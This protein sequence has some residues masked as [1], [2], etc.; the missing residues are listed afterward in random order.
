MSEK[1]KIV[2][3]GGGTAGW[4]SAAAL[5]SIATDTVCDVVLVE[6]DDIATVGVGEATIP[7]IQAFNDR[8]G[9]IELDM[10][11]KTGATFKLGI[12][13]I[14]WREKG[15]SYIHPFGAFGEPVAGTDF[16]QQWLR[17]WQAGKAGPLESYSFAVQAARQ[18][19]FDFP[20]TDPSAIDASFTY[21]YHLDAGL[22]AQYLRKFAEEKGVK[23]I[24][25]KVVSVECD[26][27][28]G[29][30]T[31][32]YLESG[33]TISGDYFLDCSGFRSLLMGEALGVEFEPWDRWLM[34]DRAVTVASERTEFFPPYTQSRAKSAGWQWRIPLQHR[35][36]NGYVYSGSHIS[37]DEATQSLL[38]GLDG[39]PTADP[40]IIKFKAGRRV[41]SWHK[42]CIALGLAGGFLEP[43]ESTSIYLIQVAIFQFIKLMP[44]KVADLALE[45]EFNRLVDVEYER[46]R[47]FLILHY[48]L[49][50]RDDSDFWRQ[51]KN[52]DVPDSL[53][54][55]VELFK[56]R[57]Y[58]D[59]YR[60]GLFSPP[61]WLSVL[62]GQGPMPEAVE[63]LSYV[64]PQ[65]RVDE[66]LRKVE[67]DISS[68]I[69]QKTSHQEFIENFCPTNL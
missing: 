9:L 10:M 46:I 55:K 13:F 67:E 60:F 20:A 68:K 50:Y 22:Y 15:S 45:K 18:Q 14:D 25:G 8:L 28:T 17:N 64:V 38:A 34:C 21:A 7:S 31:H 49:T 44:G 12:E 53:R 59:Q 65:R 32:L 57:G 36:G 69:R 41:K 40:R 1:L 62:M 43:L 11:Q 6:S 48:W 37:D 58:I 2:V 3:V 26:S 63:P 4:M 42:N 54:Q 56:R 51:C 61:S 5:A 47:D 39:K 52:M 29:N 27:S 33:E 19:K 66:S 35:T 24:E 23:R 16:H 30:I